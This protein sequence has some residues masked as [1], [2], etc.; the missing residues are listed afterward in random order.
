MRSNQ[1][2]T[3]ATSSSACDRTSIIDLPAELIQEVAGY[4]PKEDIA[5]LRATCRT[6]RD[7]AEYSYTQKLTNVSTTDEP[8]D[9][10][11]MCHLVH[12]RSVQQGAK[13]LTI[14]FVRPIGMDDES[15]SELQHAIDS[16][17]LLNG[18]EEPVLSAILHAFKAP[19]QVSFDPSGQSKRVIDIYEDLLTLVL[20]RLPKIEVIIMKVTDP[21]E[22][23]QET[24]YGKSIPTPRFPP[25]FLMA[26]LNAIEKSGSRPKE[27]RMGDNDQSMARANIQALPLESIWYL[28]ASPYDALTRLG[29][30][31]L[32]LH[33][34]MWTKKTWYPNL[35]RNA[36]TFC[37]QLNR[38]VGLKSLSLSFDRQSDHGLSLISASSGLRLP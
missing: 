15:G 31:S 29:S 35:P 2:K 21:R 18:V 33:D 14:T 7:C 5:S 30:L 37:L 23:I 26:T 13:R 27:I 9:L 28:T 4:L 19:S 32:V 17:H 1:S 34:S 3:V 38:L 8:K 20:K 22:H 11:K 24:E 16:D 36:Q 25:R 12:L 10:V 6:G